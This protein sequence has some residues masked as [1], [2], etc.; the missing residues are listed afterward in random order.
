MTRLHRAVPAVVALAAALTLA[1]CGSTTGS[2]SAPG[3]TSASSSSAVAVGSSAGATGPSSAAASSAGPSAAGSNPGGSSPA[4]SAPAGSTVGSSTGSP[5]GSSTAGG[6]GIAGCT[7]AELKTVKSG[8]LTVATSQPA[9]EPWMVDNDPTTG[10][11][12]ESAVAYAVA[13]KLG[14]ARNQVTWTRVAFNAAISPA[15]KAFDFDINQFSISED[16]KKAVDFSTGYYDVAQAV[17]TVKGSPIAG[18]HSIA[19]LKGAKLGAQIGTTSL[20]ALKAQIA[21]SGTPAVFQTN[22]TAV[23]A[24]KNGQVDGLVVDLPT[25]FFLASAE[26]DNGVLVGQ[27]AAAS[28][29]PE[30][31]GLLLE[32][33]SAVT[34]CASKAV[35]ALR[36]DGTLAA[37]ATKWLARAGAPELK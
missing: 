14:F 4:V 25:A 7:P 13:G 26:L 9:Y 1:A 16:R 24:L 22:D 29:T 6:A 28:G 32:K 35:D 31:F 20:A 30:Q 18:A 12:F 8:T 33:G 5:T 36:A 27:L 2:S 17:V 23:Q 21:P 10:K 15:P 11:G 3:T 34:G 37:L 19:D